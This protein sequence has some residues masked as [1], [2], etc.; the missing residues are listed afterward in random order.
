MPA[1]LQ[2]IYAE[3]CPHAASGRFI[4]F[5]LELYECLANGGR[6]LGR[7]S[8]TQSSTVTNDRNASR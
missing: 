1:S 4:H 3:P 5:V 8:H 7:D 2:L 6:Q